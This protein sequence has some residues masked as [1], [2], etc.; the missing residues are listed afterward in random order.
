MA[1][2]PL[3]AALALL[4]TGP[5]AAQD[6]DLAADPVRPGPFATAGAGSHP[7]R[8]GPLTPEELALARVA[9]RYFENNTQAA[10]GLANAAHDYPST[11]LWDVASYFGAV[12]A[13]NRLGLIPP[14][15][16]E[17]RLLKAAETL[18]GL[19]LSSG[20]CPNK[21][22]NTLTAAPVTYKNEP[23]D[24]GCS[25]LDIGRL[26]IWMRIVEERYP[27]TAP[28]I[29]RAV[30]G[31]GL[32]RLVRDGEMYGIGFDAEQ[33]PI[34]L[35]EGRLGYEEY[36][37]KGF[38]LWGHATPRASAPE[39]YGTVRLYG[40]A[41]PYDSR[42]PRVLGAHNYV[43]TESYAL[44]GIEFGWDE[45]ED[46]SSGPFVHSAGWMA[47]A[48]QHIYAAQERRFAATGILTARTEHQLK[49][50]PYF[51]YDTLF[52][53]GLPWATITDQGESVPQFAAVA[54]KGA[55]GLWALFDTPYTARLFDTAKAAYD[56]ER[57]FYEGVFE[58]GGGVIREF[59]ANN[60]GIILETLLYKVAGKLIE[61]P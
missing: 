36:A 4:L 30:A 42:D 33:K 51:V 41:I 37:A 23:G 46:R 9:W 60:N 54:L 15:E 17:A 28:A 20:G 10:T 61:A 18:A 24:I 43:V 14:A 45:P 21:V 2:L 47:R 5:A 16:A 57:G 58:Q 49:E 32:D 44:D 22:Y 27:A 11:S 31:W 13:A 59:T 29:R 48:A 39:P 25:A 8:S 50:A 1:R 55:L 34:P 7:G 26:L 38:R 35:Q 52:S 6:I 3:A 56:P 12:H 19:K 40:V 53:D